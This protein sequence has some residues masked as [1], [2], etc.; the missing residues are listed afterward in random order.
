MTAEPSPTD[1]SQRLLVDQVAAVQRTLS[2]TVAGNLLL[3]AVLTWALQG[4]VPAPGLA[5]WVGLVA[6]HCLANVWVLRTT[7]RRPLH[8]RNAARR[9][10]AGVRSAAVLGLLWAGGI[11][12]LWP[13]GDAALPQ[14]FLLVFLVAGVSSGALH[15]LAAHLPMFTAFFVPTVAAVALA[16]LREGGP[17]FHAVAGITAVYGLVT[18]RYAQSLNRTLIGAMRGRH[19][20]AALATQLQQQVLR[21]EQAQQARSRLLAAA[22]HDLRQPVHALSMAL[23]LLAQ[24]GLAEQPARRLALA[25]DSVDALAGQFDALLDLARIEAGVLQAEPR[26]V[27]LAPLVNRLAQ[28]LRPQAEARGLQLRVR[29]DEAVVW[30]DPQLLDRMLRN[31]L[32][33]ALRY[34]DSG[35]VLLTLRIRP[36]GAAQL[37]VVDTGIGIPAAQQARVFDEFV[38]AD[39]AAGRGG[40]GLGLAIV[41][42]CA[43]LLGHRLALRSAPGRGSRFRIDFGPALAPKDPEPGL[44]PSPTAGR[45]HPGEPELPARPVCRSGGLFGGRVVAVLEDDALVRAV[46]CEALRSEGATVVAGADGD[47]LL[48]ALVAQ[49]QVPALLVVDGRLAGGAC[50]MDVVMRLRDEYNDETLPALLVSADAALRERAR[51]AG[52]AVLRKPTTHDALSRALRQALLR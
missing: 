15:S 11:W 51:A 32:S 4:V 40:L 44:P 35:G 41:R 29:A 3:A 7:R 50:G 5:L 17:L 20:L 13:E 22:S 46:T 39:G 2:A 45:A 49:P 6:L 19:E 1:D 43:Q 10:A 42:S 23:G 47:A 28:A 36:G 8:P 30:S 37:D 21:V 18:W 34:T 26:R 25:Q 31:L 52:L 48:A 16:A 38:Q 9:A 24:E 12:W 14:R 33:N 27:A